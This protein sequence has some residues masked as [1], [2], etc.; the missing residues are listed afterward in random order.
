[1]TKQEL[2]EDINIGDVLKFKTIDKDF[3]GRVETFGET[4]VKITS[5]DSNKSKR[6]SYDL[7]KEYDFDVNISCKKDE[8]SEK[9]VCID[10]IHGAE[11]KEIEEPSLTKNTFIAAVDSFILKMINKSEHEDIG[12]EFDDVL[13]SIKGKLSSEMQGEI[14]KI[15]SW[16]LEAKK[17][18]ED[19]YEHSRIRKIFTYLDNLDDNKTLEFFIIKGALNFKYGFKSSIEDFEKGRDFQRAFYSAVFFNAE[20]E[21]LLKYA[22]NTVYSGVYDSHICDWI[23]QYSISNRRKDIAKFIY[24]TV[25]EKRIIA[26]FCIYKESDVISELPN[27]TNIESEEN[28]L[29]L[30]KFLQKQTFDMSKIDAL[31]IKS[32]E[33]IQE[34]KINDV[35]KNYLHGCITH[36]NQDRLFGFIGNIYFYIRQVSDVKLQSFLIRTGI[37]RWRKLEVKYVLGRDRQGRI[38]ADDIQLVN[39]NE[40]SDENHNLTGNIIEYNPFDFYGIVVSQG[41]SYRFNFNQVSD[42]VLSKVLDLKYEKLPIFVIFDLS[43]VKGK[44]VAV[45]VRYGFDIPRKITEELIKKNYITSEELEKR[46]LFVQNCKGR[47]KD[48]GI[49]F[50]YYPLIPIESSIEVGLKGLSS[51]E[52]TVDNYYFEVARQAEQYEKNLDKAIQNYEIAIEKRQNLSSSVLNLALIYSR[53][54]NKEDAINILTKYK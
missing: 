24:D 39:Q 21:I 23:L 3:I 41:K 19:G 53:L 48:D 46:N 52:N 34:N 16:L 54:E 27:K 51:L 30:Q 37:A 14:S 4:G 32:I 29:Y 13:R 36:F 50:E 11:E 28:I 26:I 2:E 1:M 5:I 15:K 47:N 9:T 40:F 44:N 8:N 10:N 22:I 7:I 12:L 20:T 33:V 49:S 35:Q 25:E 45:N 17:C 6:I 42:I 38:A 31:I 43:N 18:H